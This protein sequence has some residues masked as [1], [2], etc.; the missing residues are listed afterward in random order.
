MSTQHPS[1]IESLQNQVRVLT[2]QLANHNGPGTRAARFTAIM[3]MLAERFPDQVNVFSS[4]LP[5]LEYM[6]R[7]DE[8]LA[9]NKLM[10]IDLEP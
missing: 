2:E 5:E 1:E 7:I 3:A 4:E 9:A 8:L 6:R 10:V